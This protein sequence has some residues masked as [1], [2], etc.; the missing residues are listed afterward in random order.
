LIARCHHIIGVKNVEHVS[1]G[2][3]T[4]HVVPRVIILVAKTLMIKINPMN[5]LFW[6]QKKLNNDTCPQASCLIFKHVSYFHYL[7]VVVRKVAH[8]VQLH[9]IGMYVWTCILTPYIHVA[10]ILLHATAC[11]MQLVLCNYINL[12]LHLSHSCMQHLQNP[13]ILVVLTFDSCGMSVVEWPKHKNGGPIV[14]YEVW[15]DSKWGLRFKS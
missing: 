1:N 3:W 7:Y 6:K 10:Y 9:W 12:Q 8:K 14:L 15:M 2:Q 4:F 5:F 13:K 11:P